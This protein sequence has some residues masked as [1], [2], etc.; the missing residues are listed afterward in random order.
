MNKGFWLSVL[1]QCPVFYWLISPKVLG[2]LKKD[3][4]VSIHRWCWVGGHLIITVPASRKLNVKTDNPGKDKS[5]KDMQTAETI[6]SCWRFKQKIF[7]I[8]F[9]RVPPLPTETWPSTG[10]NVFCHLHTHTQTHRHTQTHTHTHTHTNRIH[11]F[12]EP[13]ITEFY[14]LFLHWVIFSTEAILSGSVS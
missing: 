6:P 9:S 8:L 14:S 3:S 1:L 2:R 12:Q 5:I 11:F 13:K 10:V 4:L 7:N